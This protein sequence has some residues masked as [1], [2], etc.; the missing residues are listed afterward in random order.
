LFNKK[1]EY[2]FG[3]KKMQAQQGKNEEDVI[4]NIKDIGLCTLLMVISAIIT[5]LNLGDTRYPSSALYGEKGQMIML[6]FGQK[7]SFQGVVYLNG[8]TSGQ[9]F[10]VLFLNDNGRWEF[11]HEETTKRAFEWT[12]FALDVTTQGLMIVPASKDF[13]LMEASFF[14][15]NGRILPIDYSTSEAAALFDEQEFVP[16]YPHFLNSMFFDEDLHALTA[17]GFLEGKTPTELTHPP[18]GK[19]IISIGIKLF[20]MTP[21]GW[22]FMCALFGV[23]LVIPMYAL[24]R[25]MFGSRGLTFLT[26]FVFS[27]DFMRFVQSRNATV[28]IFLVTFIICMYLSMYK[29]M[30]TKPEDR[31]TRKAL[32]YLGC[33]GFFSGLAIAV[34]WNGVFAVLGLGVLFALAWFDARAHY[35]DFQHK[36]KTDIREYK[37]DLLRTIKWCTL[38]FGVVPI[39]I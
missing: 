22:R 15:M 9:Q 10:R 27:F 11:C 8:E 37:N 5:F 36:G 30:Q 3:T 29:Y 17:Y 31:L 28:D 16:E 18:L 35:A 24:A 14:N 20:G 23:L 33:S 38:F 1:G 21:F 25:F 7:T 2:G 12:G 19:S 32:F 34:K 26:V 13:S 6:D 39:V 4:F